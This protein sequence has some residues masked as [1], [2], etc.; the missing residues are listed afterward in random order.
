MRAD[1]TAFTITTFETGKQPTSIIHVAVNGNDDTGNGSPKTRLPAWNE[2]PGSSSRQ[3][4]PAPFRHLRGRSYLE[5]LT[6]TTEAPIWIGRR[7][8]KPPGDRS[9]GEGIHLVR[10]R[11]IIIHNL[12][13]SLTDNNGIN[14]D[15]GGDYANAE[16]AQ[17]QIFRNLYIHHVGGSGNQDCLKLSA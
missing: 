15:D 14:S 4:D 10:A 7:G 17:Y 16:A 9:G 5:N 8:R 11:Y 12:E 3:G 2:P 1:P 6:G 13:V